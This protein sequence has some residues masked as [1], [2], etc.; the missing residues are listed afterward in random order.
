MSI[1]NVTLVGR[2]VRDPELTY[3]QGSGTAVAKFTIAVNR[4]YKD[5]EGNYPTDFIPVEVMGKSA[6][7]VSNYIT[8]GRLV[9]VVGS[10]R[11]ER[12]EKDGEKKTFTKV[13]AR[14]VQGLESAKNADVG[15]T[16]VG[17][18]AVEDDDVPF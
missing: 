16:P 13:Q 1:N 8:K 15:A 17:F 4:D 2:L 18:S 11:V 14:N 7:Y 12:Y 6:E 9:G 3:I 10:V 5:K